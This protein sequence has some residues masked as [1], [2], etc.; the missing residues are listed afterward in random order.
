MPF[1]KPRGETGIANVA[2]RSG[3]Q[4]TDASVEDLIY[5]GE[6]VYRDAPWHEPKAAGDEIAHHTH[7]HGSVGL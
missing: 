4:M 7:V 5:D 6:N 3:S 2:S 1:A